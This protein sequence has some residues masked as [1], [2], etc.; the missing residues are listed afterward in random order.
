[1][2]RRGGLR[3]NW[4]STLL[5]LLLGAAGALV[6]VGSAPCAWTWLTRDADPLTA[7]VAVVVV[8]LALALGFLA[9]WLTDRLRERS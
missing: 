1:M 4:T 3:P 9:A 2:R 7:T 5:A 6:S 8:A